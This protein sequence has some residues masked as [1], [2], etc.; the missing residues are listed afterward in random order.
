MVLVPAVDDPVRLQ[1]PAHDDVRA[2]VEDDVAGPQVPGDQEEAALGAGEPVQVAVEDEVTVDDDVVEDPVLLRFGCQVPGDAQTA[3]VQPDLL[4]V[5][6]LG[7][8][9]GDIGGDLEPLLRL[10][11]ADDAVA[12]RRVDHL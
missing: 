1:L 8:G 12:G 6:E 10:L 2:A 3:L 4:V 11:D 5:G 7:V 9:M